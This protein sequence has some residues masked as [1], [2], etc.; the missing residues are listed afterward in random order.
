MSATASPHSGTRSGPAQKANS[1]PFWAVRF[2]HGMGAGTFYGLLARNR[3]RVHPARL[4][5]AAIVLNVSV[6]NSTMSG[7]QRTLYGKAIKNTEIEHPPLF[8]IGHW[9]SGTTMLHELLV[10][11]T[12]FAFPTTYACFAPRHF[13]L[14]HRVLP[15]VLW[16]FLP[17]TRP[18]DNM[19]LNFDYPQEDEIALM[20]LGAPSPL[21]RIAFPN[22]PPPYLEFLD[23]Q[24]TD[25]KSLQRWKESMDYFVRALTYWKQKP[26]ILKSPTHTGRIEALAE[27]FPGAR[28]VHIVRDPY[29]LFASNRRL[30]MTL[31]ETQGLQ[32]P[33]HERIEDFVFAAMDRMYDGFERQREALDPAQI[34]D[35]RYEEL[36]KDPVG[37]VRAIYEKLDLGDFSAVQEQIETYVRQRK[38]YQT[39]RHE[40]DP[41]LKAEVRSRWERYFRIYES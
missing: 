22:D 36:V 39:N 25:E 17:A 10:G 24:G 40:M 4:P 14:T 13:V 18:M 41:D 26:L 33:R 6:F 27:M 5:M 30:W 29:A 34:C 35:V 38:D 8:I 1:Y 21:L 7:L 20:N 15:W 16:P 37:E 9:R 3:F 11:D 19:P 2:W 28:F 32:L 31:D 23:M 12:R